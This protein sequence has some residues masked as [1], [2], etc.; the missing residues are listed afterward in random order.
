MCDND[1]SLS[2]RAREF[3]RGGRYGGVGETAV[4]SY[5]SPNTVNEPRRSVFAVIRHGYTAIFCVNYSL[6][7]IFITRLIPYDTY[8]YNLCVL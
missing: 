2:S 1:G 4:A 3:K 8:I 7:T 5:R 6:M